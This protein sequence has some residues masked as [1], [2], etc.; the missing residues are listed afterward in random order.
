MIS[1]QEQLKKIKAGTAAVIPEE[2]LIKKLDERKKL[3]I[4]LGLDPTAPDLHLGHAVVLSKLRDFQ[5]LGHEVI[6]LV[7]DFTARI[8]DPTGRSKT[9]PPLTPPEIARNMQSYIAQVSKIL[10]PKKITIRYNSEWCDKLTAKEMVELCS[11]VTVARITEREDFAKRMAEHTSIGMHELLYP[12]FQGYDSVALH[13]DV[14]L[15]G[16]DQTFNLLMGRYLQEHYNQAP[17]VVITTPLLVGLD[18]VN[19]MSK[20]LGNAIGIAEPADQAFG[21]L[22]S[23]SDELMWQYYLILLKVPPADVEKL[24]QDVASGAKHP[25]DLKKDMAQQIITKFWSA[26]EAEQARAQFESLFQRKDYTQAQPVV[27]PIGVAST[28]WIVELLKL[29]G[30]ITTSSQGK[31]LIEEGAVS[32]D[33]TVIKDFKAEVTCKPGMVIKAGKHKIYKLS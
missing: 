32:I 30:A 19:K 11:K 10:D 15:G 18:G 20:S 8:G 17:Q 14:E 6:F 26:Q 1:T 33:G 25:M 16:T 23:I 5:D 31:R 21:K 4:K 28:M 13:S 27:L 9:R 24:K 22:M 3:R 12:L 7:G 2:D 29:V